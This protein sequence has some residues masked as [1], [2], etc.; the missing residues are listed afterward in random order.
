MNRAIP[1][2]ESSATFHRPCALNP[3]GVSASV[4]FSITSVLAKNLEKCCTFVDEGTAG[5]KCPLRLCAACLLQG[6]T[7]AAAHV[8]DFA[9]GL[10]AFHAE[11]GET[12][13]R[14]K[15]HRPFLHAPM[16][17]P[18][19]PGPAEEE[20]KSPVRKV[21]A[22]NLPPAP[23]A[24]E[25][26]D[27][28]KVVIQY[29]AKKLRR[30]ARSFLAISDAV[31]M[32]KKLGMKHKSIAHAFLGKSDAGGQVWASMMYGLR[33]IS[34]EARARI[35]EGNLDVSFSKLKRLAKQP[36]KMQAGFLQERLLLLK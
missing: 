25:P 16:T 29:H 33:T 4:C 8:T 13:K 9:R 18:I 32:M 12:A 3:L 21:A 23:K 14:S 30:D 31:V 7:D 19:P 20:R 2:N 27:W 24:N 34:P 15:A 35:L 17:S 1:L 6:F 36:P 11:K 5:C 26:V 28:K 22:K 10:C